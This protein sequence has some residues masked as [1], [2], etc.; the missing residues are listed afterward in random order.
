MLNGVNVNASTFVVDGS[1]YSTVADALAAASDGDIIVLGMDVHEVAG[2]TIDKNVTIDGAGYQWIFDTISAPNENAVNIIDSP[3][4]KTGVKL[5]ELVMVM[6]VGSANSFLFFNS[7]YLNLSDVKFVFEGSNDYNVSLYGFYEDQNASIYLT[8]VWSNGSLSY[9]VFFETRGTSNV[10]IYVDGFRSFWPYQPP[11]GSGQFYVKTYDS[12]DV[13]LFGLNMFFDNVTDAVGLEGYGASLLDVVLVNLTVGHVDNTALYTD[14]SGTTGS[15]FVD[16]LDVWYI[17]GNPI[18]LGVGTS[19]GFNIDINNVFINYSGASSLIAYLEPTGNSSFTL[20]NGTFLT[21]AGG[22]GLGF[23]L[24]S[25]DYSNIS[26]DDIYIGNSSDKAVM[27]SDGGLGVTSIW[28]N[29]VVV[30][31]TGDIGISY[32]QSY[33]L[34]DLFFEVFNT[35]LWYTGGLGTFIN[36]YPS[37][38]AYVNITNVSFNDT[39][40]TSLSLIASPS[41]DLMVYLSN[42][43]VVYTDYGA[44]YIYADPGGD[45]IID[46][47]DMW[48]GYADDEG[49]YVY[50]DP[51]YDMFLNVTGFDADYIGA[52]GIYFYH[53][54]DV[55]E[56]A[57]V[58]LNGVFINYSYEEAIYVEG[59]PYNDFNVSM[60]DVFVNYS[61]DEGIYVYMYPYEST[62]AFFSDIFLNYTSYDALYADVSSD[63]DLGLGITNITIGRSD[64]SGMDI[65]LYGGYADIFWVDIHGVVVNYSYYPGID[66]VSWSYVGY[67]N[68]SD[69]YVGEV[70]VYGTPGL[71]FGLNGGE[72]EYLLS[73]LYVNYSYG[74]GISVYSWS[75]S[76]VMNF[77][78]VVVASAEGI[79]IQFYDIFDETS[80][81]SGNIFFLEGGDNTLYLNNVFVLWLD[82]PFYPS[83]IISNDSSRYMGVNIYNSYFTGWIFLLAL[84]N[85]TLVETFFD[86]ASALIVDSVVGVVWTLDIQVL[87]QLTGLPIPGSY[88]NLNNNTASVS[89]GYTG[90]GGHYTYVLD[91]NITS[92]ARTA[93]FLKA[94]A[95]N[96]PSS[97]QW[98]NLGGTT[99]PSWYTTVVININYTVLRISGAT[100]A[101][102]ASL[103]IYGDEGVLKV[104][105]YI[106]PINPINSRLD[107][108][109]LKIVGTYVSNNVTIFD[110]L[111]RMD[112]GG[113]PVWL[114]GQLIIDR[115]TG[116]VLLVGPITMLAKLH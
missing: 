39:E 51:G 105:W 64:R 45:A 112:V 109:K 87:S 59:G 50:S 16:G 41:G 71:F 9:A 65:Y 35:T 70:G 13:D 8:D 88:I 26:L 52:V 18:D 96:G 99:L 7:S 90:G 5:I 116:L 62:Y 113:R 11:H 115:N 6:A 36:A 38:D 33:N 66:Y 49:I 42:F 23:Y 94:T 108:Y 15:L 47:T 85:I 98:F 60:D 31:Y 34:Q 107:T 21:S 17:G 46:V 3:G 89:S 2:L 56:D 30:N 84:D 77:T 104:F 106:D 29:N 79:G 43:S 10:S 81:S 63:A 57:F 110:V 92:S 111:I 54:D 61:E 28:M 44:T 19:Q 69:I 20:S 25:S 53:N 4:H 40:K 93:P 100:S 82:N 58:S 22:Y 72:T 102:L 86:E 75:Y 48:V 32:F 1:T 68:I 101:G 14:V 55:G 114:P 78:D 91:Y 12:S 67:V 80:P 97:S 74:S 24:S 73:N 27:F 83:L 103:T 95:S 76:S 37:N